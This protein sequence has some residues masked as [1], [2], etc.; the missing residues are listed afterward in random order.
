MS[1]HLS[2]TIVDV[3]FVANMMLKQKPLTAPQY[4][5]VIH[6]HFEDLLTLLFSAAYNRSA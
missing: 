3:I 4:Y 6:F 1:K 5:L 2:P